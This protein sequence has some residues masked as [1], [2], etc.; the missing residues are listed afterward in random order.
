ME[1]AYLNRVCV[2]SKDFVMMRC[3]S[4]LWWSGWGVLQSLFQP[5]VSLF[6]I[7]QASK[8]S[9]TECVLVSFRWMSTSPTWMLPSRC[10]CVSLRLC[11]LLCFFAVRPQDI[12]PPTSPCRKAA[13]HPAWASFFQS[14][15]LKGNQLSASICRVSW[16]Q[17]FWKKK[18]PTIKNVLGKK[19]LA[20]QNCAGSWCGNPAHYAALQGVAYLHPESHWQG[21]QSQI[22]ILPCQGFI[23]CCGHTWNHPTAGSSG[24]VVID[25]C[26]DVHTGFALQCSCF[27]CWKVETWKS[28]PVLA[29][30]LLSVTA[31][32][33]M[34]MPES[35]QHWKRCGAGKRM[36]WWS[37]TRKITDISARHGGG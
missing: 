19:I 24:H 23:Y 16:C 3:N 36:G 31:T 1:S 25:F 10:F 12:T 28:R 9:A 20:P 14:P 34:S 22:C 32:W 13:R 27:V 33:A 4:D 5:V 18:K 37:W 11:R 30:A 6:K 29:N 7:C 8:F 15:F 26:R 2:Q 17:V 21:C 35:K